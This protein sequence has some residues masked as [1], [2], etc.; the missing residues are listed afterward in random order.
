VSEVWLEKTSSRCILTVAGTISDAIS[1]ADMQEE[2]IHSAVGDSE[3][4]SMPD[5]II[6][7]D[8]T[9]VNAGGSCSSQSHS[10]IQQLSISWYLYELC[11]FYVAD[12]LRACETSSLWTRQ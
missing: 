11:L 8:V 10:T 2:I 5:F 3:A 6:T 4:N 12:I 9:G 1:F 7:K